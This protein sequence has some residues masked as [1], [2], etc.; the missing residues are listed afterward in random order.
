MT[1]QL[2]RLLGKAFTV[3]D[4]QWPSN[5]DQVLHMY[6]SSMHVASIIILRF[7]IVLCVF[8]HS[9]DQDSTGGY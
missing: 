1:I 7:S 5:M 9:A 3:A 4:F 2:K 6:L 8:Q